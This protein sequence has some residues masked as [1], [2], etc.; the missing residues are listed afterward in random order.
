MSTLD[1]FTV[2]YNIEVSHRMLTWKVKDTEYAKQNA[3]NE[4]LWKIW[5]VEKDW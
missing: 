4:D 3:K 2:Y 1:F 5:Y